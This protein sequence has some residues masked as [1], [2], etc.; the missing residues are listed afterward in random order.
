[1][2]ERASYYHE[3]RTQAFSCLYDIIYSYRAH[4]NSYHDADLVVKDRRGLGYYMGQLQTG[5]TNTNKDVQRNILESWQASSMKET[6]MADDALARLIGDFVVDSNVD[7]VT[8]GENI[9]KLYN[10]EG[11]SKTA[12]YLSAA[13][14]I[15][16]NALGLDGPYL[17]TMAIQ[18]DS[19]SEES[20]SR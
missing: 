2:E 16:T 1:M 7:L 6:N 4:V 14:Q 18:M 3:G 19:T 13:A 17:L 11:R 10:I 5:Y 9:D 8:L 20:R 15:T 12:S